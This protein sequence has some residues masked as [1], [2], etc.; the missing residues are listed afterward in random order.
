M[1]FT[2]AELCQLLSGTL[3]GNPETIVNHPSRIEDAG[4]GAV[5]FIANEKYLEHAST[6]NA[7]VLLLS[8]DAKVSSTK[9]RAIIRVADP[10]SSFALVMQ[11]FSIALADKKGIEQPS[12]ISSSAKIGKHVYIGAFAHIGDDVVIG[13][14]VKIFPNTIIGDRSEV[15]QNSILFSGVKIYADTKIGSNCVIHSG[16]VIGS[17]GFGHAPLPD[18]SYMKIPQ[19]GN[20]IIEDDVEVGANSTID[21]AT[22]GS[23]IIR[24]GVK[25]DNL[26]Q[27]AHNVEVGEHTVIAA[28][29]GISGSTKIGK[30]CIIGGQVGFVGHITIADGSRINA[31]SGVSKSI[32]EKNTA[33]TGSPAF[34]YTEALR[35]Q[36][37]FRHL[38]SLREKLEQLEKEFQNFKK[39]TPAE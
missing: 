20:V 17:D 27:I 23:T 33:V 25:M 1:I 37:V 32:T 4:E 14:G 5:S 38:P 12:F 10:Y 9:A 28:Q 13:D 30:R 35:A 2:A 39:N 6:T 3:E 34:A 7:S 31:Q 15:K 24:R 36:V 19:L 21:R 18:G 11:K 26:V 22:L 29:T 16:V 8:T